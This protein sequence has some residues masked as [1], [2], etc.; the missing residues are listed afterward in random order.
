MRGNAEAKGVTLNIALIETT[1]STGTVER[2]QDP[3]RESFEGI[4]KLLGKTAS[5][6]HKIKLAVFAA[7]STV[8]PEVLCPIVIVFGSIY[9]PARH[10][11]SPDQAQ[12]SREIKKE[13]N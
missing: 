9:R 6:H 13:C 2:Y 3:H 8:G 1:G 10:T 12:W 5:I 4:D 11:Q 7:K